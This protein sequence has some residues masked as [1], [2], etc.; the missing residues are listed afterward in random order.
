[1]IFDKDQK[2]KKKIT[3][4]AERIYMYKIPEDYTKMI[5]RDIDTVF[6]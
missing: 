6:S 5:T 4:S 1:M 3:D 2:L